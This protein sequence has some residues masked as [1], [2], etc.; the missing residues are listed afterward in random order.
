MKFR[1]TLT[2]ALRLSMQTLDRIETLHDM[3]WLSRDIKAN[4][5]A[6]GLNDDNQTVYIIDFGFARRFK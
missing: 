1:F 5:F 3:G 2:T 6:I 4:N